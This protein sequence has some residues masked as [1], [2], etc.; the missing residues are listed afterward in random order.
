MLQLQDVRTTLRAQRRD[1]FRQAAQ[2]DED[3][4]WLE[5]DLE[6]KAEERGQTET[7]VRLLDRADERMKGETEVI[8]RTLMRIGSVS[9]GRCARGGKD[10]PVARLQAVPTATTCLNCGETREA[11][12]G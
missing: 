9:D 4:L 2:M 1:L 10:I 3:L 12:T 5:T 11:L 6:S 8:D 7:M